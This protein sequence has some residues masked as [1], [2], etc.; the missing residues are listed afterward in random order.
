MLISPVLFS[1]VRT[2]LPQILSRAER[3]QCT[4]I[5]KGEKIEYGDPYAGVVPYKEDHRNEGVICYEE[6]IGESLGAKITGLLDAV[7]VQGCY[8]ILQRGDREVAVLVPTSRLMAE[9]D[10]GPSYNRHQAKVS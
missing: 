10:S 3:N 6:Q 8:V 1:E 2:K 5:V 4:R 7:K 9:C